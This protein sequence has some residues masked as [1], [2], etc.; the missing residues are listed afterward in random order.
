MP[1]SNLVGAENRGFYV[2]MKELAW[3]RTMI[4]VR[5]VA[6]AQAALGWTS[7]HA[8]DRK[9]FG[10]PLIDMQHT[11]F[12]LA[13]HKARIEMARVFVDRC[14]E[15]MMKGELDATVAAIAKRQTTEML[16]QTLD[17]CVQIHG[18]YGYMWEY[19]VC[20]AY[21]DSRF[22]R[23]AGGSNE[24]MLDLIARTL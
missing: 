9:M 7:A 20:R 14:L 17:D 6:L 19:P 21:A 8:R 2:L 22:S 4:A 12:K 18:G 16:M 10:A 5:S 3:E 13:E 24:T 15:L 11:R 23:I 1:A